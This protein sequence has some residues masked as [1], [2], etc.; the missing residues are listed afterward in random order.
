MARL[1]NALGFMD[2]DLVAT[3]EALVD[4][5]K[6]FTPPTTKE[7]QLASMDRCDPVINRI[8]DRKK[9]DDRK[10]SKEWRDQMMQDQGLDT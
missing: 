10:R 7:A 1:H 3:E 8:I 4:L 9:R 5:W 2:D 6:N